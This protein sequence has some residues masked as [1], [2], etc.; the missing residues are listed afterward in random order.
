M[1]TQFQILLLE[2]INTAIK[3]QLISRNFL[4]TTIATSPITKPVTASEKV[5]VIGIVAAFVGDFRNLRVSQVAAAVVLAPGF[6][7]GLPSLAWTLG[8]VE[9]DGERAG[10]V[11]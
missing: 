10:K 5:I 4:Q 8:G 2:L 3:F 9:E 11:E 7:S 1:L 6:P